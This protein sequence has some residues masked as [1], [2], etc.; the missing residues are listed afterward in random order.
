MYLSILYIKNLIFSY[1]NNY[2]LFKITKMTYINQFAKD[3]V[4]DI[5]DNIT[6]AKHALMRMT[7]IQ[8]DYCYVCNNSNLETIEIKIDNWMGRNRHGWICC[9]NCEKYVNVAKKMEEMKMS[10][11]PYSSTHNLTTDNLKFWRKSLAHI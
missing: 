3:F 1:N 10:S 6:D 4:A 2:F 11:L 9:Q 5:F 8:A 7:F